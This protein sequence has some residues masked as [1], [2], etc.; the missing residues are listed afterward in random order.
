MPLIIPDDGSKPWAFWSWLRYVL[1]GLVIL[2]FV[3]FMVKPLFSKYLYQEGAP[4]LGKRIRLILRNWLKA[5]RLAAVSLLS[6]F[7][8]REG[9]VKVD[10]RNA[11]N[12]R[13]LT[14][15][16][17]AG[18]SPRKRRELKNSV[19]LFLRLILWGS[20]KHNAPWRPSFAPAEYCALLASR[21]APPPPEA[22]A[23]EDRSAWEPKAI[24]RCG[25]LFEEAVYGA[26]GL[27]DEKRKEFKGLIEKITG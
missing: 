15:E 9:Q 23:V 22:A 13:R 14:A 8:K 7:R 17:L 10:A 6:L 24:L 21:N 27:S 11:S 26:D 5:M 25:G 1:I 2:A 18:Y 19:T 20:E 12:L 4:T 16:L 3:W